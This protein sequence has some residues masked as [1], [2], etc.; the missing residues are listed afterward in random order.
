MSETVGNLR[1]CYTWSYLEDSVP[2]ALMDQSAH[3]SAEKVTVPMPTPLYEQLRRKADRD[4][5][6]VAAVARAL[7][8]RALAAEDAERGVVR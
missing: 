8:A 3:V 7:I 6:K 1:T 5:Q 4:C 2:A